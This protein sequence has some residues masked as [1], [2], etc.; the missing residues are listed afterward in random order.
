[1]PVE[2]KGALETRKVLKDY[3]P[4][5][6][7]E[8]Q[9]EMA[10][11]LKPIVKTARGF[12][13]SNADAPSG[14]LPRENANGRWANRA[15]DVAKVRRGVTYQTTPT[16]ANRKG[17][18]ALAAIWNKSAAGAIYETAGRKSGVTGN[19]SPKLGGTLTGANQKTRGRAIFCAWSQDQGKTLTAVMKAI[20]KTNARAAL[21][22]RKAQ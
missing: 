6:A 4:D 14:W 2:V 5:L 17:F 20:E 9:K 12:L 16:K 11:A 18:R 3:A 15:Y 1:M 13:P 22:V 21:V 8:S 19:F 7:K 10:E